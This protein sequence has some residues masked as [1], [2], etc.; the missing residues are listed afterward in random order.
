MVAYNWFFCSWTYKLVLRSVP[1]P[2]LWNLS[3]IS[4][5][6]L[7]RH[8]LTETISKVSASPHQLLI[9]V[10]KPL[11]SAPTPI[12]SAP[13]TM[14]C[15]SEGKDIQITS[16]FSMSQTLNRYPLKK[17][18]YIIIDFPSPLIPGS[19]FITTLT[20]FHCSIILHVFK[21]PLFCEPLWYIQCTHAC[22]RPVTCF[23]S[24]LKQYSVYSVLLLVLSNMLLK[25]TLI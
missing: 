7:L 12:S 20:I 24:R 25:Q 10:T 5:H 16:Y 4:S 15:A 18:I 22:P 6:A 21:I 14:V 13:W 1:D 19:L 17:Q 2:P 8:F 23:S 11:T 3:E 9:Q